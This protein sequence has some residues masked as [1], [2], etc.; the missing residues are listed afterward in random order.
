MAT[1]SRQHDTMAPP[2]PSSPEAERSD[3]LRRPAQQRYAR[4]LAAETLHPSDFYGQQNATIFAEMLAMHD[5]G[6][7]IDQVSLPDELHKKGMLEAARTGRA[8]INS[9]V[10]GVPRVM[11]VKRYAEIV[12]EKAALRRLAHLGQQLQHD[13]LAAEESPNDILDRIGAN[14]RQLREANPS[15]RE[16]QLGSVSTAELFAVQD[17]EIDWLAWPLAAVGLASILDGPPKLG[18]TRL[19][20]RKQSTPAEDSRTFLNVATKPMR[21]IYVSEQSQASLAMQAREVGF[22]GNEPIEE[23][24]WITREFWSRFPFSEFLERLEKQFIA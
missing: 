11:H 17:L 23:L 21:A 8:Y 19:I 1:R 15:A 9:L 7:A 4:P 5:S 12:G 22:T 24:R 14:I 10:D 6:I 20:L 13:A 3:A 16:L 18:K 2:L